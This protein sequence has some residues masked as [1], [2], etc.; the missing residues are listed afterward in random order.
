MGR[1]ANITISEAALN[2]LQI[3]SRYRYLSVNQIA[4]IVGIKP[5][6]ASETLLRLERQNVLASFGNTGIRGYGK[7]P[8]MYYLTKSGHSLLRQECEVLG[9]DVEPYRQINVN[10]RWSPVMFHRLAT[11]D[12]LAALERDCQTLR[13]YKL[14]TTLV[15]YRRE[16]IDQSWR[17]ETTD[18][19]AKQRSSENKIVPDAGFVIEHISSQKRAL[20]L[21]EL[22]RGT[23]RLTTSRPTAVR[24][25]FTHKMQQYDR[26]LQSGHAAVR[27]AH[28][29]SFNSFRLLVITES[30][31]RMHNMRTALT[32]LNANYHQFY[33][34]STL[35]KV[36]QYFLHSD[37]FSRDCADTNTYQL[38]KG[39]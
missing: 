30:E 13:D 28:L 22:D 17:R 38:I 35:A 3:V 10:S 18:Y 12:A 14:V 37:W 23:E 24:Q 33:R 8:K 15:E 4:T 9:V 34:F 32:S 36:R 21:V 2:A 39:Q 1:I 11:L 31:T 20:F 6:T 25:T 16:K 26:Y 5:K 19:V 7:T 27:Y 29:G